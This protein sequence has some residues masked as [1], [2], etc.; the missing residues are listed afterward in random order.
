MLDLTLT[1]TFI[2]AA[3]MLIIGF[4]ADILF[5]KAGFPDVLFLLILG[6][7]LGP[8]LGIISKNDLVPITPYLI[9]LSLSARGSFRSIALPWVVDATLEGTTIFSVVLMKRRRSLPC[10]SFP[11]HMITPTYGALHLVF[12]ILSYNIY[13]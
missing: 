6:I 13:Y 2:L 10:I 5:R 7:I 9:E 8:I 4:L 11:H 12:P 1:V 3:V